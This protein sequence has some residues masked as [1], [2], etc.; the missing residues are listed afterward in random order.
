MDRLLTFLTAHAFAALLLPLALLAGALLLLRRWRRGKWSLASGVLGLAF[1][2]I[3]LG[4][5]T[6]PPA[7]GVWLVGGAVAVLFL[8]FVYLVMTSQWSAPLATSITAIA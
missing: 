7:V 6:T 4:G 3:A 1:F 8:L 5:F 2:L